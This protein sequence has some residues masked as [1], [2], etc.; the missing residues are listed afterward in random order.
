MIK[1]SN[2]YVENEDNDKH[3]KKRLLATSSTFENETYSS[4]TIELE[5][6]YRSD[7]QESKPILLDNQE[8][9]R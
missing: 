3:V 8:K 1:H 7:Q 6:F 9:L 4:E 2:N 5:Y